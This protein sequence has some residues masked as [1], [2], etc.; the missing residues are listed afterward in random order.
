LSNVE[1]SNKRM[2]G[3]KEMAAGSAGM[4]DEPHGSKSRRT[5][6][7]DWIALLA[8]TLLAVFVTLALQVG[9]YLWFMGSMQSRLANA[10][11]RI[12][13]VE[14]VNANLDK[15][16]VSQDEQTRQNVLLTEQREDEKRRLDRIENKLDQALMNRN[17]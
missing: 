3:A 14:D 5:R 1:V 4:V 9:A 7:R 10:E 17:K 13:V 8:P 11:L 6:D 2:A 15:V 12:K 16:Y